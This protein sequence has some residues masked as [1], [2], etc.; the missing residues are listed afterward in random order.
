M[1]GDA[2][3]VTGAS[4][5]AASRRIINTLLCKENVICFEFRALGRWGIGEVYHPI[6]GAGAP[7]SKKSGR[8][9]RSVPIVIGRRCIRLNLY[10]MDRCMTGTLRSAYNIDTCGE[11]LGFRIRQTSSRIC[12]SR[13]GA[14]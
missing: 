5:R 9:G 10:L 12:R 1:V 7:M 11:G 4:A 3:T 8:V 14:E 6:I 2:R 13:H